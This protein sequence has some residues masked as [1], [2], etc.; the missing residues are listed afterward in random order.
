VEF[1]RQNYAAAIPPLRSV[2]REDPNASQARYLLGLCLTFTQQ[3]AAAVETLEPLWKQMSADV[4]YLYVL[5]IA[6]NSSGNTAVD[7]R[8]M[9]QLTEVGEIHRNST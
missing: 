2:V 4:M 5:A 1:R 7:E 8:A 3:Y 9:K 6:A